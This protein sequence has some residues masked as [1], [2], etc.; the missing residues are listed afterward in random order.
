MVE[1]K[2]LPYILGAYYFVG[3]KPCGFKL[4]FLVRAGAGND[5]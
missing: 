1:N 2:E 3:Y 4:Y 5:Q